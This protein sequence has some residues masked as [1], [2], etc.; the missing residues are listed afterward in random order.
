MI[1][2]FAENRDQAL[3]S[4]ML[5]VLEETLTLVKSSEDSIW[6]DMYVDDISGILTREIEK[7]STGKFPSMFELNYLFSPAGPIQ[8]T[9]IENEWSGSYLELSERFDEVATKWG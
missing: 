6:S 1:K 5:Y 9:S 4:D 8:E 7:V 2:L 3:L